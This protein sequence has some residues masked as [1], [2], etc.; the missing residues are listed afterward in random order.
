MLLQNLSENQISE[1]VHI[2]NCFLYT[3]FCWNDTASIK[4]MLPIF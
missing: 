2:Q 3:L 1:P 4:D